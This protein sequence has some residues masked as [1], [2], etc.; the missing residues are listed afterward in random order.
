MKTTSKKSKK[1]NVPPMVRLITIKPKRSKSPPVSP[2][3]LKNIRNMQKTAKDMEKSTQ[4]MTRISDDADKY[5]ADMDKNFA[6]MDKQFNRMDKYFAN[7]DDRF[8]KTFNSGFFKSNKKR[9]KRT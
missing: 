3:D 7:M 4:D 6:N 8:D 1:V 9:N 2:E 5:F